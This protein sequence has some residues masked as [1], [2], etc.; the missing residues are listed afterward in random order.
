M[1]IVPQVILTVCLSHVTKG[2]FRGAASGIVAVQQLL[3]A[4]QYFVVAAV[5]GVM[6][7]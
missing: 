2:L 7:D 3:Q 5:D 1:R 4:L 6:D